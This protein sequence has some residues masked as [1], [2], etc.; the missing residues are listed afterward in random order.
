[1]TNVIA[2]LTIQE[3]AGRTGLSEHTLRY[4]ERIGLLRPINRATN[5]HRRYS[6]Q[7]VG[8]IE[9]FSRLRATGMP[10]RQMQEYARLIEVGE[11][12]HAARLG[13]LESHRQTVEAQMQELAHNL[14]VI[15]KKIAYYN[16][17]LSNSNENTKTG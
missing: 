7:D 6:E 8:G 12:S 14:E 4:Y 5:G 3:V 10:I 16:K 1:M 11:D 13:L 9:F 2:G 15:K 17:E